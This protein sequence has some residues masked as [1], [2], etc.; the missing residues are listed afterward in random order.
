MLACGARGCIGAAGECRNKIVPSS[1]FYQKHT[2]EEQDILESPLASPEERHG[3]ADL[4]TSSALPI[5][6]ANVNVVSSAAFPDTSL[7]AKI[8]EIWK[9]LFSDIRCA[10]CSCMQHWEDKPR[11]NANDGPPRAGNVTLNSSEGEA[12]SSTRKQEDKVFLS[13]SALNALTKEW[14]RLFCAVKLMDYVRQV[15]ECILSSF[16]AV[17][18][19]TYSGNNE[20][21]GKK[22]EDKVRAPH[23]EDAGARDT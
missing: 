11:G 19:I 18:E 21:K 23:A 8:I 15:P 9:E 17:P 20:I 13:L 10:F 3:R 2:L 22:G 12:F 4:P 16:L 1:T 6:G 14:V 5:A 7:R